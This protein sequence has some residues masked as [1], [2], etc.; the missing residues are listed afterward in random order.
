MVFLLQYLFRIFK[1]IFVITIP[2]DLIDNVTTDPIDDYTDAQKRAFLRRCG[3]NKPGLNDQIDAVFRSKKDYQEMLADTNN[4]HEKVWKTRFLFASTPRGNIV[5]FFDVYKLGFVYYS[6]TQSIPYSILNAV[7]MKY[8][9]TFRCLDF[10]M[11]DSVFPDRFIS[12]L[13]QVHTIDEKKTP[14]KKGEKKVSYLPPSDAPFA[15]LKNYR[16]KAAVEKTKYDATTPVDGTTPPEKQKE[17]TNNRF[18]RLGQVRNWN[19]LQDPAPKKKS[20]FKSKL[21]DDFAGIHPAENRSTAG[22]MV[23]AE[24]KPEMNYLAYKELRNQRVSV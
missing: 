5:M 7:A 12:P 23:P 13:I 11:D 8:V 24:K 3:E 14:E 17:F 21:F 2:K 4:P 19:V 1:E 22:S 15:K 20:G 10:F 6:D 9:C 16:T 18:I